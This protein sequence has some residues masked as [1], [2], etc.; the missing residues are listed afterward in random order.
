MVVPSSSN[1]PSQN[2][3]STIRTSRQPRQPPTCLQ[4][5]F[6]NFIEDTSEPTSFQRAAE[7]SS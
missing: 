3:L 1:T 6:V 7:D 2:S 5:Y 4:E